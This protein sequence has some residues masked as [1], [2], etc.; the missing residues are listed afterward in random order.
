M[1]NMSIQKS[2]AKHK[3]RLL[4]QVKPNTACCYMT[5]TF[6]TKSPLSYLLAPLAQ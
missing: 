3:H 1:L 4:L 5:A 6:N 2:R